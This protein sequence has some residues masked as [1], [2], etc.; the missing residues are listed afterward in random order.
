MF[1]LSKTT[2][3]SLSVVALLSVGL[4]TGCSGGAGGASAPTSSSPSAEA[5]SAS[6]A[7]PSDFPKAVP[8]VDG[9]IATANG[10]A[11]DGWTATVSPK[12]SNGFA[13]AVAALKKAG[14]TAQPG[15]TARQTTFQDA[16]Y[17]VSVSTPGQS[18]TYIVSTR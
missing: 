8:L 4:L 12:G 18:V 7:L 6:V 13:G 17:S 1:H 15:A 16:H 2:S 11:N 14:F 10:D 5:S 3:V 9:D